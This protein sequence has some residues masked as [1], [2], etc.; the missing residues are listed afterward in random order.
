MSSAHEEIA[1]LRRNEERLVAALSSA[2]QTIQSVLQHPPADSGISKPAVDT[3]ISSPA[4]DLPHINGQDAPLT[5][6]APSRVEGAL[7][8]YGDARDSANLPS[9]TT[10]ELLEKILPV[11]DAATSNNACSVVFG[12]A[13]IDDHD[14]HVDSNQSSG[15]SLCSVSVAV[16]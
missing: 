13:G 6:P 5:E 4:V 7:Y 8:N 15:Q 1:A 16:F 3:L 14:L 10:E 9:S 11:S 12:F 2:A